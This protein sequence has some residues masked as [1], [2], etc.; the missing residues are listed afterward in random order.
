MQRNEVPAAVHD[1]VTATVRLGAAT[2]AEVAQI[3]VDNTVGRLL[4]TDPER[5]H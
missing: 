1:A 2:T 5:V 4:D 3:V